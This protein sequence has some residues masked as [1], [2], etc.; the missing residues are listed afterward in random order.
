MTNEHK[1]FLQMVKKKN[2]E[3]RLAQIGILVAFV[4]IWELAARTE[5]IDTFITSSPTRIVNTIVM[6][7]ES[8]QLFEHMGI[9]L[10]EACLGFVIAT[11]LGSIIAIVLWWSQTLRRI[12]DPYVVVLNSLPKIALGP[13]IIIWIGAGLQSIVMICVLILIIITVIS[14]LNAF[15]ECDRD[16]I[17]LMKSMGANKWQILTKLV[18]PSS[19]PAF[20]SVLKINV[21]MSWVGVIIG[22]YLVSRAGLGYLI[23]Y[24]SAVF[25]LD[26]VMTSTILLCILAG[27]MYLL[28][29][30]FEAWVKKRR[31]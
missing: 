21:G 30:W 13:L 27:G 2:A 7:F 24:G 26:L 3:V 23:V 5:L 15:L 17:Q 18:L 11:M 9:T 12:L 16:K 31:K 20:I 28:V 10:L 4:G 1:K 19:I 8:G 25:K 6:L 22:E 14:M 29:A